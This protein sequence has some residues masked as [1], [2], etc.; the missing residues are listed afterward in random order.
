[1]PDLMS[2]IV[3]RKPNL[4]VCEGG[5]LRAPVGN[6]YLEAGFRSRVEKGRGIS[7]K[8]WGM[9]ILFMSKQRRHV[10]SCRPSSLG[11]DQR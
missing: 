1:M 4:V 3:R 7:S 11:V 8:K 10:D 5:G 9:S 6:N 2:K